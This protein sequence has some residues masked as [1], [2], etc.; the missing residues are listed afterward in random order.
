[1]LSA[2]PL[3]SKA[4]AKGIRWGDKSRIELMIKVVTQNRFLRKPAPLL[5]A[6]RLAKRK[7]CIF[8]YFLLGLKRS[9]YFEST[10]MIR[11]SG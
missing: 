3:K 10:W 2:H 9:V 4:N 8:A 6:I 11:I 7:F 1:M 5:P